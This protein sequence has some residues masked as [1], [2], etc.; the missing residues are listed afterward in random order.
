MISAHG[1][2]LYYD[3]SAH[4]HVPVV[5]LAAW[6]KILILSIFLFLTLLFGTLRDHCQRMS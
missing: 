1:A 6:Y 4:I 5:S 3:D 2:I